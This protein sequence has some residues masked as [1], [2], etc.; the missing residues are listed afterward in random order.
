MPARRLGWHL[1]SFGQ[2]G[3]PATDHSGALILVGIPCWPTGPIVLKHGVSPCGTVGFPRW[4]LFR[5]VRPVASEGY[6]PSAASRR[7]GLQDG[8]A[9]VRGSDAA[10]VQVIEISHAD[11]LG[12]SSFNYG[13]DTTYN[14]M[15]L[16]YPACR[17]G[18]STPSA[19]M[20]ETFRQV[21][22]HRSTIAATGC[23]P[24][25]LHLR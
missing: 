7:H 11:G 5:P 10:G 3:G 2:E 1:T 18:G 4:H 24:L 12:G 19:W 20:T 14:A 16:A 25:R 13:I 23:R 22:R 8:Y 15:E 9:I 17:P 6:W 21:H